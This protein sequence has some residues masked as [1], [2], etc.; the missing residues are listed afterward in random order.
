[1]NDRVR[2]VSSKED[3]DQVIGSGSEVVVFFTAAWCGP[4]RF[5]EPI[6]QR[7]SNEYTKLEFVH[8][9]IDQLNEVEVV[10]SVRSVPTFAFFK[11]D[12]ELQRFSGASEA[13]LREMIQSLQGSA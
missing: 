8:A 10:K 2:Q 1:M 11:H 13:K 6:F 4:G 12:K 5:M 3:F 9:D 7:L